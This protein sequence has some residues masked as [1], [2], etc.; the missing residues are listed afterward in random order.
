MAA[1][2]REY[3]SPQEYLK[4]ERGS[5]AKHEYF[6]GQLIAMVGGTPRHSHLGGNMITTLN[7]ALGNRPC[8]VYNSDLKVGSARRDVYFYPDVTVVC[9]TPQFAEPEQDVLLNPLLIVEILSPSTERY[10]RTRKFLRYQR[11]PG[12]ADYLLVAQDR[13][14]VELCSR[15]ADDHWEWIEATGLEATIALPSLDCT[16]ALADIYRNVRFDAE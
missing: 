6:D 15:Q 4:L 16:I 11:I 9:G 13:P 1:A 12:F 10:D 14:L 8:I 5:Q 7:G 2:A 3:L